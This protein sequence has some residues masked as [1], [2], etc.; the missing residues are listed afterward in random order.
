M[1]AK[2]CFFKIG[3]WGMAQEVVAKIRVLADF[4]FNVREL[5]DVKGQP[6][7]PRDLL[8]ELMCCVRVAVMAQ[9]TQLDQSQVVV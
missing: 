8:A 5:V 9:E 1:W 2:E 7:V 4:G 3:Y 6:A